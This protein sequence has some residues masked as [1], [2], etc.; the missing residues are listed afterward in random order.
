[1]DIATI[2]SAFSSPV[3]AGLSSSGAPLRNQEQQTPPAE[4]GNA[5][6]SQPSNTEAPQAGVVITISPGTDNVT[7]GDRSENTAQITVE[8]PE[9]S[10]STEVARED[11]MAGVEVRLQRRTL[12]QVTGGAPASSPLARAALSGAAQSGAID[13]GAVTDLVLAVNQRNLNQQAISSHQ[14]AAAFYAPT[15]SGSS[16]YPTYSPAS[17]QGSDF[18]NTYQY[19]SSRQI[20]LGVIG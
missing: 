1:M 9:R 13:P 10:G 16:I 12:T 20:L 14:N 8:T 2:S 4:N 11:V 7:S 3:P 5:P 17:A 6:G 18:M 19:Y 15:S